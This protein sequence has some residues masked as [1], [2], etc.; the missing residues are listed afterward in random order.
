MTEPI[1]ND[2]SSWNQNYWDPSLPAEGKTFIITP[3]LYKILSENY[4]KS[5]FVPDMIGGRL[6]LEEAGNRHF[7]IKYIEGGHQEQP[8]QYKHY[9]VKSFWLDKVDVKAVLLCNVDPEDQK[10]LDAECKDEAPS[11]SQNLDLSEKAQ[12]LMAALD[13]APMQFQSSPKNAA[14]RKQAEEAVARLRRAI[15]ASQ[16]ELP[17]LKHSISK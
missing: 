6:V 16:D 5:F 7:A 17:R 1:R 10:L 14:A 13:E 11:K 8:R 15:E 2:R 4:G 9:L 12:L 3:S